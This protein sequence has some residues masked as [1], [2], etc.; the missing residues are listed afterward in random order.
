MA[1]DTSQVWVCLLMRCLMSVPLLA[2]VR[3]QSKTVLEIA[4]ELARLQDAATANQLS[5]VGGWVGGDGWLGRCRVCW[6]GSGPGLRQPMGGSAGVG[7]LGRAVTWPPPANLT[8]EWV[9]CLPACLAR[10]CGRPATC[11]RRS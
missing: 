2:P 4:A 10:G 1:L 9:G 8:G 5:Q 7:V 3:L 6:G 11:M